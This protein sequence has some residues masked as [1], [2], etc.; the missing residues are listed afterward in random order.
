MKK[1]IVTGGSDGLGAEFGKLC[2]S[3]GI[4]VVCLSR[5]APDYKAIHIKTD[6]SDE[7]SIAQA[8]S[9]IEKKHRSFDALVNCAG[10][11]S[12]EK[13]SAISYSELER[14]F[15]VNVLAPVFLTSKLFNLIKTN[16]ADILNVGSSISFKAYEE[17]GV[18]G[19]SKWA[20]RGFSQN[21]LLELKGTPCRVLQFNPGG[22]KSSFYQRFT[23]KE[24][25]LNRYKNA[26]EHLATIMFF[27]LELPKSVEV[28]EILV[29]RK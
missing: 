2:L 29:N 24:A 12:S 22:F 20:L 3:K 18:Y 7:K 27:M 21:L 6:L 19:A 17:L 8:A 14:V 25:D 11:F 10:V 15:K 13:S 28:S 1:I 4:E 16:G 23:K 5:N 9:A 26:P